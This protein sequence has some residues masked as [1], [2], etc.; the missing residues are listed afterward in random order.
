MA[1]RAAARGRSRAESRSEE[2]PDQGNV[3]ELGAVPVGQRGAPAQGRLL[4]PAERLPGERP[5]APLPAR[6][7]ED[8]GPVAAILQERHYDATMVPQRLRRGRTRGE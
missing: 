7:E 3:V 4:L 1:H 5:D 6:A 2:G 8:R